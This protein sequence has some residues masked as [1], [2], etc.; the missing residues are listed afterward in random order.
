MIIFVIPA[1]N[2]EKNIEVLLQRTR[3]KMKELSREFRI[4]IVDDGSKDSTVKKIKLFQDELSIKIITHPQN[5]GVGE[6]FKTGF[7]EALSLT[8]DNDIIITK[9]ADNTSDLSILNKMISRIEEGN[10]LVLASCFAKEG[11]VQG[12]TIFRKILSF[13]CNALLKLFFSIPNVNTYSSFYRAYKVSTLRRGFKFYKGNLIE[14]KGFVCMAE[15][16]IKL[17]RLPIKIAE[18]PMVL[19][20]NLRPDESKMHR[21]KTIMGYFRMIKREVFRTGVK[22]NLKHKRRSK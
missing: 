17:N 8:D 5:R 16:L 2:E 6:V 20:C 18:V 15:M 19:K 14:E 11:R 4:I 12:T 22:V 1:Y 21:S 3:D 10:D 9:E 13:S 7:R